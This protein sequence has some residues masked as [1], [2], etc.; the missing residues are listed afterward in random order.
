MNFLRSKRRFGVY[1][2]L[3]GLLGFSALLALWGVA[4][5]GAYLSDEGDWQTL[6][7]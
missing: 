4:K 6:A 1:A 2:L 5:T 3:L 7:G